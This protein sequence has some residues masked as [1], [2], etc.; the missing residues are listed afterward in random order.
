MIG[1]YDKKLNVLNKELLVTKTLN[2]AE[3]VCAMIVIADSVYCGL[4]NKTVVVYDTRNF[5]KFKI[6]NT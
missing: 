2:A 1:E 5:K 6:I 4:Q 3:A